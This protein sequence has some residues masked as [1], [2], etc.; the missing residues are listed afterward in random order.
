MS[1]HRIALVLILGWVA[2][3]DPARAF[4]DADFCSAAKQLAIAAEQD[5]GHWLDRTTRNG[6]VGVWCDRKLVHFKRFTY[7]SSASMNNDW[8]ARKTAEWNAAQCDSPLWA[9]AIQQGWKIELSV[10]SSDGGQ[11]IFGA[12]F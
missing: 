11:S 4:S 6:G 8:K 7:A 3:H 2:F 5:V 10:T 1:L 9:E 12:K